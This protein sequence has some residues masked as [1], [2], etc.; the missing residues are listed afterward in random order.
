MKAP[1]WLWQIRTRV[2]LYW[3]ARDHLAYFAQD[4]IKMPVKPAHVVPLPD[5][6]QRADGRAFLERLYGLL[7][8]SVEVRSKRGIL[9]T[10]TEV[11]FPEQE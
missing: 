6:Q 8:P 11:R 7:G 4:C 2:F 9:G 10:R 1:D 5:R 3:A